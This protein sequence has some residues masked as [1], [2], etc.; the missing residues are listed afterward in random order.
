VRDFIKA[1][2]R[3]VLTP[4]QRRFVKALVYR[5]DLSALARALRTDKQQQGEHAY[6]PHY[7]RHFAG[8]RHRA[9]NILEI[10]IGGYEDPRAG[11]ASLQLWK[12]YF[13][14]ARVFGI[15][16]HDKTALEEPRIKTFRGDQADAAF[17]RRVVQ[18]IGHV[19]IVIDDGSHVNAHVI[20]A[21]RALFPLLNREGLY[22]VEDLQTSYWT[23]VAGQAW[24]G[25]QDLGAPH[26]SMTFFKS[27][28]DGLNHEEFMSGDYRPTYF[29]R[30][31]VAMHFYHNLLFIQKG[32]N[33]EGSNV[34]GKRFGGAGD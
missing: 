6:G 3:K 23:E 7:E 18:E 24:G 16:L 34:F 30:H 13:P 12:A 27:L 32:L 5:N 14:R 33:N 11:G 28:V 4:R 2:A 19:D 9:L 21:F 25:S 17:L 15:D 26:T 8:L 31:I 10:G 22:V 29:D 20:A 1:Q